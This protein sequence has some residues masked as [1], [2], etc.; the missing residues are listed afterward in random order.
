MTQDKALLTQHGELE[1]RIE[2]HRG[3]QE[4]QPSVF[5]PLSGRVRLLGPLVSRLRAS[6]AHAPEYLMEAA[7]LAAFMISAC[8][9]TALVEHPGSPLPGVLADADMR[10][11]L[12][13]IAMGLT[14]IALIYSPWGKRSGAHMNPAVTLT[15]LRLGKIERT[16][17]LAYV[18][19]QFVGGVAGVA[20]S[21]MLLGVPVI[22]HESVNYVVTRPGDAGRWVAFAAEVAIAGVL[23]FTVLVL[24][25][26]PRL[27][28][29]T[30][31]AAGLL[32][33]TYI[34][35]EA[36]LSGMSMNPARTVGSAANALLWDA[37]WIYFL[38]PPLG[39]LAAAELYVRR[40]GIAAV[41]CCKLHHENDQRCIFRCNY[42]HEH[43]AAPV[44]QAHANDGDYESVSSR[45][46]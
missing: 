21:A 11:A 28:R 24:S 2:R 19:A 20:V 4:P 3:A 1:V 15:F 31:L 23:M 36:P 17:A 45:A 12:I 8:L 32:V 26:R 43:A 9:F 22:A 14:A 37:V 7:L 38:A 42:P 40:R 25:N 39:M 34:T 18:A 10:R 6:V 13:G 16:D 46:R 33:A 30:G 41:L 44:A 27:N 5:R 29:Y 35:I